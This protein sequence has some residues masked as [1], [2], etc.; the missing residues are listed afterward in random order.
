[1]WNPNRTKKKE[2]TTVENTVEDTATQVEETKVVTKSQ[3]EPAIDIASLYKLVEDQGKLIAQL[4]KGEDA[5]K[6]D[7]KEKYQGELHFSYKLRG[8]IPVLGYKSKKKILTRD[9]SFKNTHW[10]YESN[11][12]LELQLAD[13]QTMDVE[14]TEFNTSV[15]RSPKQTAL[16]Q[17]GQI[18]DTDTKLT[19]LESYTFEDPTYGTIKVLP[20]AIN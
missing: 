11:H 2:P 1:M 20:Y 7:P 3:Q 15:E 19:K 17:K 13:W 4:Q 14:V 10:E 18:I 12:L 9:W 6:R 16:D 8:G 5:E